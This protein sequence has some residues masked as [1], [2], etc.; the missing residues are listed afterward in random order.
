MAYCKPKLADVAEEYAEK[1]IGYSG[2]DTEA[3]VAALTELD[4]IQMGFQLAVARICGE[5]LGGK[6]HQPQMARYNAGEKDDGK[7]EEEAP[8]PTKTTGVGE[9]KEMGRGLAQGMREAEKVA[10]LAGG[11]ATAT[12]R[13]VHSWARAH[14]EKRRGYCTTVEAMEELLSDPEKN[15]E[16]LK[17]DV[18][19][20]DSKSLCTD[21]IGSMNADLRRK[22]K[23]PISVP[24]PDAILS[25]AY[26]DTKHS[27][28]C[29]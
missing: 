16:L 27:G 15:V 29:G 11:R 4:F 14:V 25:T 10:K 21:M 23:A 28:E 19:E 5:L 24:V 3:E 22:P 6:V 1:I 20:S 9:A 8:T 7:N 26:H 12:V 2:F 13:D 18:D 17:K